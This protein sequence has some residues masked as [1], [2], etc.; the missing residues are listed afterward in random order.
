[1]HTIVDHFIAKAIDEMKKENTMKRQVL[2][3][4]FFIPGNVHKKE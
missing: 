4:I 2:I 1:M 3:D